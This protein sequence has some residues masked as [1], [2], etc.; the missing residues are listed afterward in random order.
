MYTAFL[1]LV[2]SLFRAKLFRTSALG[3]IYCPPSRRNVYLLYGIESLS[4]EGYKGFKGKRL[5]GSRADHESAYVIGE[6]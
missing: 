5:E 3:D 6:P 4:D 2:A 1:V